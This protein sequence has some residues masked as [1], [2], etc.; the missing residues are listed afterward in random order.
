MAV[1]NTP[2]VGFAQTEWSILFQVGTQRN[3]LPKVLIQYY[4]V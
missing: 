1:K 2:Y 3:L 4:T